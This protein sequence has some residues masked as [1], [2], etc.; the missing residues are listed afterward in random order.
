MFCIFICLFTMWLIPPAVRSR[1]RFVAGRWDCSSN[2][3]EGREVRLL[4][5]L[6]AVG[7]G[8]CDGPIT[9][10]W[11]VL[12]GVCVCVCVCVYVCVCVFVCVCVC[13]CV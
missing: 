13:V 12:P 3:A 7:S 1:R 9:R 11:G 4:C 5:L 10:S 8:L 2:S 6:C